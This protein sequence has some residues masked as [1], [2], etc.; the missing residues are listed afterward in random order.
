MLQYA[1]ELQM[2]FTQVFNSETLVAV[3]QEEARGSFCVSNLKLKNEV[4]DLIFNT[5]ARKQFREDLYQKYMTSF[6][7][8]QNPECDISL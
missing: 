7:L 2:E 5:E 8:E 3:I 4:K 6:G 1:K